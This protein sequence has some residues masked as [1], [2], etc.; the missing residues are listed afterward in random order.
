MALYSNFFKISKIEYDGLQRISKTEL[1]DAVLGVINYRKFF[2]FPAESYFIVNLDEIRD[3]VKRRFP[4]NSII[5]K[6]VFPN[7][8]QITLEEKISTVIY[9]S[10]AEYS[11]LGMEGKIVEIIQKVGDD[12]WQRNIEIVTSTNE[13]GQEIQEEKILS[14][15]HLPNTSLIMKEMGDYPIVYDTRKQVIEINSK[16]VDEKIVQGIIDWFNLINK[17]TN[18]EFDYI[19]IE[20]EIGDGVIKTREGWDIVVKLNENVK[21]QFE[22]LQYILKEKVKRNSLNYIDLRFTNKVYWQ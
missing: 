17:T 12:E 11:Y 18:I 7:T 15:V 14:E 8:L 6:K 1:T 22:E 3:I 4:I 10:G 21:Q 20:N 16:V 2:I 9:D 13:L 19:I 5:V